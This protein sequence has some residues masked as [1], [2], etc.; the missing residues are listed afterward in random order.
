MTI[1]IGIMGGGNI[2]ETHARAVQELQGVELA[3][4]YGENA[5]RVGALAERHGARAY[6]DLDAFLSHRPLDV[7]LVGSP[8]GRHA[9]HAAAA[10]AKGLHVLV[11][12]P[13]DTSTARIDALLETCERAGVRLGV[14]FQDRAAPDLQWLKR[15]IEAGGLGR[16]FLA[17]AR[18]RWYR[19]PAYYADSRWRGTWALDGGGAVMNQ[20]I[21][22]VDL[23]LW[24]LGDVESVDAR[25]R[26]VLHAIEV[27]DTAV[28]RIEFASGAVATFE[29]S[30]AAYPGFPR[31]LELTGTTGTVV[32]EGD[33]VADV[34]LCEP[35][36]EAP[37]AGLAS[38]NPSATS[39]AVT[40][41]QGHRRIIQDFLRAL[42]T[43]G[44]LLCD[45]RE[46]RRSV[47]V[48]EAIYRSARTG[49][50]CA[51]TPVDAL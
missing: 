44:P 37:P 46:G 22:T 48:V 50:T 23:L 18:V 7:V 36:A 11:E 33:R 5:V 12:K 35:P 29:A 27:E 6:H 20:G 40:D 39:A 51:L 28:A 31:R 15:L 38:Q 45:G 41:V 26:T 3:A 13:L 34:A 21:H 42:E 4:V 32:V 19:A 14:F 8:S 43:G 10:A 30:T 24:L 1:R 2:G 16:P 17:A 25:S 49:R 47:E 9:E